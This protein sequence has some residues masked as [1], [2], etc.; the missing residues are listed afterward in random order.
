MDKHAN[1]ETSAA[2]P[3]CINTNVTQTCECRNTNV[4]HRHVR[5]AYVHRWEYARAYRHI[6]TRTTR[7]HLQYVH[8]LVPTVTPVYVGPGTYRC[9]HTT[10]W[11]VC[12][13]V[14]VCVCRLSIYEVQMFS[15]YGSVTCQVLIPPS[16]SRNCYTAAPDGAMPPA[17]QG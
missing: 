6:Q 5:R 2:H 14:C 7:T 9:I 3:A 16:S 13:C 15:T 12:V 4:K 17:S 10:V 1:D 8:I 11:S